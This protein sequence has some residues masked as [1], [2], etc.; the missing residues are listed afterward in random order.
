MHV[1]RLAQVI[2]MIALSWIPEAFCQQSQDQKPSSCDGVLMVNAEIPEISGVQGQPFSQFVGNLTYSLGMDGALSVNSTTPTW[3]C[4]PIKTI[5]NSTNTMRTL[6]NVF[7]SAQTTCKADQQDVQATWVTQWTKVAFS[8]D[9]YVRYVFRHHLRNRRY[10]LDDTSQSQQSIA[11]HDGICA[12]GT[13]LLGPG[14]TCQYEAWTDGGL[15]TTTECR[16]KTTD[17]QRNL[18]DNAE[19]S[20]EGGAE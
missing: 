10:T 17:V 19:G 15:R 3:H 1:K 14:T 11:T 8:G 5:S 2:A 12:Y 6:K 16:W 7:G 9:L 13:A 4:T 18:G 20:G